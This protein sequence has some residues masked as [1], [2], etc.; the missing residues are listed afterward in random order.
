[1]L[2]TLHSVVRDGHIKKDERCP[3]VV[4]DTVADEVPATP[5]A[6]RATRRVPRARIVAVV[7]GGAAAEDATAVD[8]AIV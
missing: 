6:L 2:V 8:D 4:A 1:M 7:P 3:V 5:L